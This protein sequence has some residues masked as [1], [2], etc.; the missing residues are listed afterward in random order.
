MKK[1]IVLLLLT[2]STMVF[3]QNAI[4]S[5]LSFGLQSGFVF[6][7]EDFSAFDDA[8]TLT[9]VG[10][11]VMLQALYRL[12]QTFEIPNLGTS[13]IDVGMKLGYLPIF[14]LKGDNVTANMYTVP[15]LLYGKATAGNYFLG[16]GLGLHAWTLSMEMEILG[17]KLDMGDNGLEGCVLLEPGYTMAINKNLSVTGSLS[18]YNTSTEKDDSFVIGLTVGAE[19]KL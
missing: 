3:S 12:D 7:V 8:G 17:S 2:V 10:A 9:Q 1:I 14:S 15:V 16:F 11:P 18:I 5:K 13:T 19:Y 6:T 4:S